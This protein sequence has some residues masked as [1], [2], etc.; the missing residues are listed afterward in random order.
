MDLVEQL[1]QILGIPPTVRAPV[2]P[3]STAAR[4]MF[5]P[6]YAPEVPFPAG[7]G[8]IAGPTGAGGMGNYGQSRLAPVA[9]RPR[10]AARSS[11]LPKIDMSP[12][13]TVA[14]WAGGAEPGT[15]TN[16]AA[17]SGVSTGSGTDW[18]R[19]FNDFD[20]DRENEASAD[21]DDF[22]PQNAVR[23]RAIRPRGAPPV[24]ERFLALY[25]SLARTRMGA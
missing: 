21:A 3:R 8:N 13:R 15:P 19:V 18:N 22:A 14:G 6:G 24:D 9:P 10:M 7:R 12:A 25:N 1:L 11:G 4:D 17:L 2:A 5:T 16:S 20:N 23:Q